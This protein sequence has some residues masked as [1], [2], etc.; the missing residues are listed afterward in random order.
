MGWDC[1]I[2][3]KKVHTS[4]IWKGCELWLLEGRLHIQS[5]NTV[6]FNFMHPVPHVKRRRLILLSLNLGQPKCFGWSRVQKWCSGISET[7]LKSLAAPTWLLGVLTFG[8]LPFRTQLTC[9][10][11]FWPHGEV[12]DRHFS[13]NVS[14]SLQWAL[15]WQPASIARYTGWATLDVELLWTFRWLKPQLPSATA[16]ETHQVRASTTDSILL[17]EPQEIINLCFN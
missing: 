1:V 3:G 9:S 10:R 13:W 6:T 16:W 11:E 5:P 4:Y 2:A 12:T 8:I 7:N 17:V 14:Y 15:S